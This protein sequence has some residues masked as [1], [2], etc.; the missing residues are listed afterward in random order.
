MHNNN[1]RNDGFFLVIEHTG[2]KNSNCTKAICLYN[3]YLHNI[4]NK[5]IFCYY[6]LGTS[7]YKYSI[8]TSYIFL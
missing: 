4:D 3:E 6:E 5:G 8:Y 2:C 1:N 7:T